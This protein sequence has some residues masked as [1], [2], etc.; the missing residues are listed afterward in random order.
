MSPWPLLQQL[1]W[2]SL[3]PSSSIDTTSAIMIVVCFVQSID[4]VCVLYFLGWTRI[5]R[6][7]PWRTLRCI[8]LGGKYTRFECSLKPMLIPYGWSVLTK[9]SD[10]DWSPYDFT[11]WEWLNLLV[12]GLSCHVLLGA[13]RGF[14]LTR[15]HI[16][17]RIESYYIYCITLAYWL[18]LIGWVILCL[19]LEYV[20]DMKINEACCVEVWCY[21]TGGGMTWTVFK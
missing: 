12:C 3:S 4:R 1:S 20:N 9:Q 11:L 2:L 21:A 6:E 18:I 14:S 19:I 16:A 7:R 8:G 10:P 17:Y 13:R 5:R 15:Y